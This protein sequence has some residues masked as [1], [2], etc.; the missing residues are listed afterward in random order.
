MATA[1]SIQTG[2][3]APHSCNTSHP[4]RRACNRNSLRCGLLGSS[5]LQDIALVGGQKRQAQWDLLER[6]KTTPNAR[7]C[8]LGYR[9]TC[10][11]L[12]SAF[13]SGARAS[14]TVHYCSWTYWQA[15]SI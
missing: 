5:F 3:R 1:P 7:P 4:L 8:H 12:S 11:G 9:H 10:G 14:T 2:L 15:S 13:G 6:D